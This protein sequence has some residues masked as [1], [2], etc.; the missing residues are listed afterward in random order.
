M[1][2]CAIESIQPTL[3]KQCGAIYVVQ[4][5]SINACTAKVLAELQTILRKFRA[6]FGGF[7]ASRHRVPGLWVVSSRPMS[8]GGGA[9]KVQTSG[10]WGP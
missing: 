10:S 8:V 4:H 6:D 7:P 5:S 9:P 3:Y 1:T 2:C